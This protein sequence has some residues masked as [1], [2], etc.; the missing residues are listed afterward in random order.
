MENG[1]GFE[2][3]GNYQYFQL[4]D[5]ALAALGLLDIAESNALI[6]NIGYVFG[7]HLKY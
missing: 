3:S 4:N 2:L 1:G 5:N 6:F 7:K